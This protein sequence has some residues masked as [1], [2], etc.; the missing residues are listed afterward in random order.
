[1]I[2]YRI[3]A[4]D[5]EL[6]RVEDHVF[7]DQTWSIQYLVAATGPWLFGRRTLIPRQALGQ[8]DWTDN[9]FPVSLTQEQIRNAPGIDTNAP[10]SRRRELEYLT[11][12]GWLPYWRPA[13][14][15]P[16]GLE[17]PEGHHLRSTVEVCSYSVQA[18]H[19]VAGTVDDLLVDDGNWRLRYLVVILHGRPPVRQV[20]IAT[21]WICGV[22]WEARALDLSVTRRQIE[23]SPTFD[24][25]L[26][27]QRE[28][29]TRL[30]D[31]YGKPYYWQAR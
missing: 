11:Y 12:F 1:M 18:E 13:A 7:D 21:D 26:P 3:Q 2:G 24:P 28:A 16:M 15:D 25:H 20:L 14:T 31:Y 19:I 4:A 23:V 10:V 22:H 9:C 30:Y 8:P 29:E 6:G 5:G 27:A 17:P